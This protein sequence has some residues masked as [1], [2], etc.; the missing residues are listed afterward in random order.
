M[1]TEVIRWELNGE[2]RVLNTAG[3]RCFVTFNMEK[4]CLGYVKVWGE[5]P[6]LLHYSIPAMKCQF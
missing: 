6:G 5:F 4:S 1:R 3:K 2:G